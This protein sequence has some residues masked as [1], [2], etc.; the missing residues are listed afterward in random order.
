M[1]DN[2][3]DAKIKGTY[4]STYYTETATITD[5]TGK[6]YVNNN[7]TDQSFGT[8]LN[9]LYIKDG[10]NSQGDGSLICTDYIPFTTG[11]NFVFSLRMDG[12]GQSNKFM[13]A[14]IYYGEGNY[15]A[16]GVKN[17]FY[18]IWGP[19][20][21]AEFNGSHYQA[22]PMPIGAIHTMRIQYWLLGTRWRWDY[23]L[24]EIWIAGHYAPDNEHRL[25]PGL[26]QNNQARIEFCWG[27]F[28]D[29]LETEGFF[30]TY[31]VNT[32]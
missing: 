21:E 22:L 1:S 7:S 32:F 25:G 29:G 31:T 8:A 6:W 10:K 19:D 24:N 23:F 28:V 3:N 11:I 27:T 5:P 2:W 9:R 17:G 12:I 15:R 26:F 18:N 14:G 4:A 13:N 20:K 16:I 30:G